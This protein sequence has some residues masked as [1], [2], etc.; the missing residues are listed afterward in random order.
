MQCIQEDWKQFMYVTELNHTVLSTYLFGSSWAHS[1]FLL[2]LVFL[3][4]QTVFFHE[5]VWR[6]M[7]YIV[8]YIVVT[9]FQ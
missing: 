1:F 2:Q 6:H 8:V 9:D 4:Q 3:T 7:L 5:Q